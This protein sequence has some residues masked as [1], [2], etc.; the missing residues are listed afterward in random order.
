MGGAFPRCSERGPGWR[1]VWGAGLAACPWLLSCPENLRHCMVEDTLFLAMSFVEGIPL[2]YGPMGADCSGAGFYHLRA[3]P[4]PSA[5]WRLCVFAFDRMSWRRWA[6]QYPRWRE[7]WCS[8]EVHSNG[9]W[10]RSASCW[11]ALWLWVL[12]WRLSLLV[13]R[14]VAGRRVHI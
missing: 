11:L 8:Q 9:S 6:T 7:A 2:A 10:L 12:G 3:W 13:P 5:L 14:R 4:S 1:W